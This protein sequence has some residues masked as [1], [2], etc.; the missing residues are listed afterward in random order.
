MGSSTGIAWTDH[1]F[2][3]WWGCQKVSE[4]CRNCY[5]ATLAARVYPNTKLWGPPGTTLRMATK[6]PWNDVLKWN[7][8]AKKDGRIGKVFCAS[9]ADFFEQHSQPFNG[10]PTVPELR[11][12]A[13]ELFAKCQ[14][15]VFQI[16][17]KRPENVRDMLPPDW[18]VGP[19]RY[20]NIWLGVS[21]ENQA[22]A[23]RFDTLCKAAAP[24]RV[25]FV[26][27]EPALGPV[28]WD[29]LHY[30]PDWIIY[31]GESGPGYR[32]ADPNWA[33]STRDWCKANGTRFFHKQSSGGRPGTGV[34][35]DGEIIQEFPV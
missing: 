32:P 27:Y 3:P 1:T 18:F 22:V 17:T 35:L 15:L 23:Y 6:G 33:R 20:R 12:K 7:E 29:Q 30:R 26:S 14:H 16:L 21:I 2:N 9:M 34:E 19:E 5:A 11:R 28:D 13:W 8:A 4:G 24:M 31:G 10:S 25:G